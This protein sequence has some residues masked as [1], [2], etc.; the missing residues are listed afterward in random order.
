[1][2][3]SREEKINKVYQ[4]ED[5]IYPTL[6]Q[7]DEEDVP[8]QKDEAWNPKI[9]MSGLGPKMERPVSNYDHKRKPHL[10]GG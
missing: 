5:F 4:D 6:D 3:P 10:Q 7:S 1:M 9:K 8:L 2:F